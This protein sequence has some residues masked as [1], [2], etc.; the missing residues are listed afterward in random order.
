MR[1]RGL[2]ALNPSR[3]IWL[4]G[5]LPQYTCTPASDVINTTK[6]IKSLNGSGAIIPTFDVINSRTVN[7][8][9]I[10][11][12]GCGATKLPRKL[13]LRDVVGTAGAETS[14]VGE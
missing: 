7:A 6:R 4:T 12:I 3:R 9:H 1:A 5:Y 8:C 13:G 11:Y 14:G 2:T 10:T